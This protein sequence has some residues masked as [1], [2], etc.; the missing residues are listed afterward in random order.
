ML[1]R[2]ALSTLALALALMLA[3]PAWVLIHTRDLPHVD[4][5]DLRPGGSVA[6]TSLALAD[7]LARVADGVHNR[8]RRV[9]EA[10]PERPADAEWLAA[11]VVAEA[12]AFAALELAIASSGWQVPD[13]EDP[14]GSR[15]REV[16]PSLQYL[17]R[18]AARAAVVEAHVGSHRVARDHALLGM[19]V[20]HA[21]GRSEQL[22]LLA[23]MYG[24]AMRSMSLSA[25]E[26]II[27]AGAVPSDVARQV[28]NETERLRD[29]PPAWEKAW[30][31]EYRF[32]RRAIL[33]MARGG[34]APPGSDGARPWPWWLLP[35]A[36]LLQPNRTI[37]LAADQA[38]VLQARAGLDCRSLLARESREKRPPA[39][40]LVLAPNPVGRIVVEAS[41]PNSGRFALR[42][43]HVRTRTSLLQAALAVMAHTERAGSPPRALSD[44]VPDLLPGIPQDAYLGQPV[45]Y[46]VDGRVSSPG[47]ALAREHGVPVDPGQLSLL[48]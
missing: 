25:L 28:I 20:A 10:D 9:A 24:V 29:G 41:K 13:S 43:C 27:R 1:R 32:L 8:D 14:N 40:Q 2:L 44:L 11:T 18:L 45:A 38:R 35:N 23:M 5:A 34:L 6:A 30:A 46:A 47:S 36:Y 33:D 16:L 7:V 31:G 12:P 39:W 42:R 21:L 26:A 22:D 3:A 48:F 19:R 17:V 4:D 37:A 15:W